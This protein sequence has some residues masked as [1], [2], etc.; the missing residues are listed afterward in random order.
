MIVII[1]GMHGSG[2]RYLS[3]CMNDILPMWITEA[4]GG[5]FEDKE[6]LEINEREL[7]RHKSKWYGKDVNPTN[8]FIAE[9]KQYRDKRIGDYGFKDPRVLLFLDAYREVWPD[10]KFV[11][12]VRNPIKVI[13]SHLRNGR[14]K[15]LSQGMSYYN[16]DFPRITEDLH[17]FNYDNNIHQEQKSLREYLGLDIDIVT[18]WNYV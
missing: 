7:D 18:N 2:T 17:F 11:V 15:S 14:L 12:C 3:K 10:A 4:G 13:A 8:E 1:V 16:N 5:H 6:I 9:L